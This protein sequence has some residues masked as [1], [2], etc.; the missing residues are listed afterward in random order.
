MLKIVS[1][2]EGLKQQSVCGAQSWIL[3]GHPIK[4][5]SWETTRKIR[6]KSLRKRRRRSQQK[7]RSHRRRMRR[8]HRRSKRRSH[9]RRKR[10]R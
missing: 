4:E 2:A 9:K 3:V 8:S 5:K 10:R 7:R 6:R 1:G